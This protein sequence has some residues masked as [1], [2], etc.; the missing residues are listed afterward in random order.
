M[1]YD[2]RD[3][4][5]TR[6]VVTTGLGVWLALLACLAIPAGGSSDASWPAGTSVAAQALLQ[7][8][9]SSALSRCGAE[10]QPERA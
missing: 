9:P 2:P 8:A 1:S 6:N 7:D 4:V 10:E 3:H 5:P